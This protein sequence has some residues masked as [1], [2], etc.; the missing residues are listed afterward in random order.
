[1]YKLIPKRMSQSEKM[2]KNI[3]EP[4]K[5]VQL[6]TNLLRSSLRRKCK[7]VHKR[8]R[9]KPFTSVGGARSMHNGKIKKS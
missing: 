9:I 5:E 7:T 2:I 8:T 4:E 6:M 1:M 3:K